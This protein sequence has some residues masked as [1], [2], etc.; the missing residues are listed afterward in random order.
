LRKSPQ[1]PGADPNVSSKRGAIREA[2]PQRCD[3]RRQRAFDGRA[4]SRAAPRAFSL[5]RNPGGLSDYVRRPLEAAFF[6]KRLRAAD[7][8]AVCSRE[9]EN[10][11]GTCVRRLSL[12]FVSRLGTGT[13]RRPHRSSSHARR[14]LIRRNLTVQAIAQNE[15]EQLAADSVHS[16]AWFF[17]EP[18]EHDSACSSVVA[19][20]TRSCKPMRELRAAR[21]RKSPA[22]RGEWCNAISTDDPPQMRVPHLGNASATTRPPLL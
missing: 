22:T 6:R 5:F 4:D 3:Q 10:R 8:T 15:P 2:P 1:H 12:G 18:T 16:G 7:T 9:R 21:S 20:S 11:G 19:H 13:V 17:A 14:W